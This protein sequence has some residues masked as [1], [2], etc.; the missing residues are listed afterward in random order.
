MEVLPGSFSSRFT[1][2]SLPFAVALSRAA[3]AAASRVSASTALMIIVLLEGGLGN[4][5]LH[6]EPR[7]LKQV[8]E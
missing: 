1:G 3:L 8:C 7:L 5:N 2:A 6:L 4:P